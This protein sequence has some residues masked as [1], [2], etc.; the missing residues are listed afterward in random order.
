MKR[1][2]GTFGVVVLLALTTGI[3][4]SASS[5][6]P[7]YISSLTPTTLLLCGR[8]PCQP[9]GHNFT[10][11]VETDAGARVANAAVNATLYFDDGTSLNETLKTDMHGQRGFDGSNLLDSICVNSITKSGY[12]WMDTTQPYCETWHN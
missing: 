1:W 12:A 6:T 7:L 3:G 5:A 11:T 4:A 8:G 9:V 10:V 2:I